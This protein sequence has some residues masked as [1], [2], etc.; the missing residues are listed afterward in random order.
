MS[1][2]R[3]RLAT[4]TSRERPEVFDARLQMPD[5]APK[6]MLVR[7]RC[8]ELEGWRLISAVLVDITRRTRAIMPVHLYGQ[9][10]PIERLRAGL[11]G[12]DVAI[13]E[14]AAQSQGATRHGRAAG[15]DGIAAAGP[16]RPL[17]LPISNHQKKS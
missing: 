3:R 2:L 4:V 6:S 13:V 5:R 12:R 14:D 10:A 8:V 9:L 16:P 1:S 7:A 11:D 17:S 15:A